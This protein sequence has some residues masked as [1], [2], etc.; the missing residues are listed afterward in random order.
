MTEEGRC[1]KEEY[2]EE[3]RCRSGM[4][5]PSYFESHRWRAQT[6][7]VPQIDMSKKGIPLSISILMVRL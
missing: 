6:S 7:K 4:K 3:E 1:A 5:A 2:C